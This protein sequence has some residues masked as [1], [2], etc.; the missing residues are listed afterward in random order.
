MNEHEDKTVSSFILKEKRHRYRHILTTPKKRGTGLDRLNHCD[1]FDP[2]YAN[3]LPSNADIVGILKKDGS[4]SQVYLISAETSLDGSTL[5][6]PEA[7]EAAAMGGWGT[8]VSCIPS[9]LAYYYDECGE[10]RAILR[11]K[12]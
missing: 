9:K 1:D 8:I 3:W 2:R 4:P 7:V 11:R 5:S 6:L 12:N 10:R